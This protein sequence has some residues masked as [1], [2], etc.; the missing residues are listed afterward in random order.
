MEIC[1]QTKA[2]R[3]WWYCHT[4]RKFPRWRLS[5]QLCGLVLITSPALVCHLN[6]SELL[7]NS[8]LCVT[9]L[10]SVPIN[11]LSCQSLIRKVKGIIKDI[12]KFWSVLSN[13]WSASVPHKLWNRIQS[14]YLIR[15]AVPYPLARTTPCANEQTNKHRGICTFAPESFITSSVLHS[16]AALKHSDT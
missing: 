10:R 12:R 11:T 9:E 4:Q 1:S 13:L 8:G 16:I 6:I 7:I 14:E 2:K 3:F 5:R 15:V